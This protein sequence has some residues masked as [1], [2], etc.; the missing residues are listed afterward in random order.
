MPGAT[1]RSASRRCS[2]SR[3][4]SSSIP[5]ATRTS[6][7]TSRPRSP[8][9]RTRS[10]QIVTG[11][12][13]PP[14]FTTFWKQALQQGF[15]P[16]AASVGKAILFPV[17][18][19]ALGKDG[20]NLSSEVW[21]SPS[22]PFKSSLTGQ[23]AKRA[24]RCLR[25]RHQEAVDPADRLHPLAV[26]GGDR[27]AEAHGGG[28]QRQGDRGGDRGNQ[29]R[30][31]RRARSHG[32]ARACRRSPPRTSPRRRWSAASGAS[33]AAASTTSSSPTTGPRRRSRSAEDAGDW[34]IV[35]GSSSRRSACDGSPEG[36]RPPVS[37]RWPP[38]F[39]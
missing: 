30:H 8:P 33:R 39:Y 37:S 22:H 36:G 10:C 24:R 21:W 20:H 27:R 29:A 9:S 4:T 35:S 16:K 15:K 19:E 18:V 3:A 32:T 14:D 7:T 1:S 5:A 11:V 6:P 28:R 13:L 31:G 34:V 26:R 17:A 25:G 38:S 23:S 2:R 12:V